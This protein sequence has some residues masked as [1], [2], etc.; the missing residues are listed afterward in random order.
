MISTTN[1]LLYSH[2]IVIVLKKPPFGR[3]LVYHMI[4]ISGNAMEASW[5]I[6]EFVT[7]A[8]QKSCDTHLYGVLFVSKV[9]FS[10]HDQY[11]SILLAKFANF[12]CNIYKYYLLI[13]IY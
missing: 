12:G 3:L 6:A 4:P 13:F 5:Y 7:K 11:L 2:S 10:H 8:L 1:E 9:T